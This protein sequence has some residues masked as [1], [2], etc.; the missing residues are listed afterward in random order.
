M[1]QRAVVVNRLSMQL[2]NCGSF[3]SDQLFNPN[4]GGSADGLE[5]P[6]GSGKRFAFAG[7]IWFSGVAS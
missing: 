2:T 1:L 6:R 5:F 3:A 4:S 7:G